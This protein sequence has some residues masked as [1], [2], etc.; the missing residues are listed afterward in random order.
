MTH[1]TPGGAEQDSATLAELRN[2]VSCRE[3]VKLLW[4]RMFPSGA[5]MRHRYPNCDRWPLALLYPLRWS[6]QGER[7]L[8]ALMLRLKDARSEAQAKRVRGEK[9]T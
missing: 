5:Y 1:E 3:T 2:Q 8:G 7:I 4:T 9:S 6:E